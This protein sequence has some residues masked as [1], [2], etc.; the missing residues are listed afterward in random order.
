MSLHTTHAAEYVWDANT[1]T[2]GAQDGSNIS[3][4]I[5]GVDGQQGNWFVTPNNNQNWINDGTHTATFGAAA[6]GSYAV[7][8]GGTI[9]TANGTST[10]GGLNF[11][12]SGY[13]LSASSA[14]TINLGTGTGN[15]T[16]AAGV[17]ATIGDN[18]SVIK[19]NVANTSLFIYG[20]NNA[21][22]V[23]TL[24]IGSGTV[25]GGA[26]L[27]SRSNNN[28]NVSRGITL[29]VQTGGTFSSTSSSIVIGATGV[30][31]SGFTNRLNVNGG[32]V[33]VG[34]NFLL[35]GNTFTTTATTSTAE[36]NISAGDI[37]VSGFGLR[38]GQN[39]SNIT[40]TGTVNL[41]GGRITVAAV[42][43]ATTGNHT[44]TFNF[45]GGELRVLSGSSS[46][47][48]MSGLNTAQV[49]NGG[50]VINT[51]GVNSTIGQ[52][53]IHSTIGGDNAIDGGL[54]KKGTGTLTLTGTNTYTGDTTV[55]SG[56]LIVNGSI[57]AATTTTVESGATISG[58]GAVGSLTVNA[59]GSV[60]PGNSPG[61]LTVNGNYS[62]A[63]TLV[64]EI[65]G[66]TAGTQHDQLIVNGGVSLSGSLNAQFSAGTYQLNDMI[67]LILN[68]GNDAI[69]GTFNGLAQNGFVTTYGGWDWVVSY[70]ANSST[71]SFTG[72][73][74]VALRAIPETSTTL[75]G[76]LSALALLRRRRK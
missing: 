40:S 9:N 59:G 26:V 76:G 57:A 70:N 7:T 10:T 21:S 6:G 16:L 4:D 48:F 2:T 5:W 3:G 74:D 67:F 36:V 17:T 46:A 73:N 53:L 29:D 30:A 54:T 43:E 50:A 44:S 49:R 31:E 58:S 69:T 27:E 47:S 39:N 62:Q 68:D 41:N 56:G 8:V 20:S 32:S 25:N 15:L 72:G 61:T 35:L 75:L 63:G 22:N 71:N 33:N 38:F 60:N 65:T 11:R 13:T 34:G 14:Q 19:N 1:G 42:S 24:Q 18:V 45:N 64:A 23:A 12:Q 66:L 55:Q 28:V 37:L 52:S 51:N